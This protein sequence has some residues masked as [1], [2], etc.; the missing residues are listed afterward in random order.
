MSRDW[1]A[2]FVRYTMTLNSS[3]GQE[4]H[5]SCNKK[6]SWY[7]PATHTHI[8]IQWV[9]WFHTRYSIWIL[10]KI[11]NKNRSK[12]PYGCSY[13]VKHTCR[14]NIPSFL[15]RRMSVSAF[16]LLRVTQSETWDTSVTAPVLML[17]TA[18]RNDVILA[19]TE[20]QGWNTRL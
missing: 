19:Q 11:D 15:T 9:V 17:Q 6:A 3:R 2:V 1:A 13:V 14:R 10:K 8:I 18:Q 4:T 16:A 12:P 5:D 7:R 20:K